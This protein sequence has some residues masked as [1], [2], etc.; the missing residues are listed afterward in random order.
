M[1]PDAR[2]RIST[3]TGFSLV[4]VLV[5]SAVLSIVLAIMLGTM[6]TS[7]SLWRNTENKLAADREGRAAELL[8]AQDLSGVLLPEDKE[9]W[10]QLNR[11]Y[12][13]FL[14]AKSVEYQSQKAN[15]AGDVCFVEYF[16]DQ[17]RGQITRRFVASEETYEDIIKVGSFPAPGGQDAQLVATNLLPRP[18]DAVRGMNLEQEAP[19]TNIVILNEEMLPQ[20]DG[21]D[22]P[23]VAVEVNFAVADPEAL[24]NRDLWENPSY[25]FRNAGLYSFRIHFPPPIDSP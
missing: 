12:L 4:E 19:Q 15:N 5:A 2:V 25:R 14:T 1:K 9:L 6:A 13:Q 23:P 20:E 16:V 7:L 18:S 3:A 11:G 22:N 21:D 24:A 17:E 8:M 10:P